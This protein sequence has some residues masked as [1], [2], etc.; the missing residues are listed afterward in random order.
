MVNN[1]KTAVLLATLGG[2]CIAVGYLLGGSSGMAIGLV[3]GLVMTGGSYWY[4]DKLAIKAAKAIEIDRN[5]MPQYHAIMADLCNRAS[6][7]MPRLYVSRNPQPN[8]FATGRN[9]EHA[10][11]CVVAGRR[12]WC[13]SCAAKSDAH[14]KR[15][16]PRLCWRAGGHVSR[17]CS[18]EQRD[19]RGCGEPRKDCDSPLHCA[20]SLQDTSAQ[21]HVIVGVIDGASAEASA[22]SGST[23]RAKRVR[24]F[25][26]SDGTH[27]RRTR[28]R[29]C[30]RSIRG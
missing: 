25:T 20:A 9:P 30:S 15:R 11:V 18:T 24:I 13:V 3:L 2:F 16:V 29:R 1:V 7:P 5:Q 23:L 28:E 8:A 17:T 26:I 10:A 19:R 22:K 14:S 27:R 4:S 21:N 12:S 6:L